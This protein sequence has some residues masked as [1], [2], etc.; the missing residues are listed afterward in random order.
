M[1]ILCYELKLLLVS[2]GKVHKSTQMPGKNY[3][4]DVCIQ[5]Y[6]CLQQSCGSE[7]DQDLKIRVQGKVKE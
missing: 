3:L 1:R 5:K 6:S 4:L 2:R 7:S